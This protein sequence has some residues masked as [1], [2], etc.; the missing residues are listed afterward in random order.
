MGLGFR[1]Y[2]VFVGFMSKLVDFWSLLYTSLFIISRSNNKSLPIN[3][4]TTTTSFE[5]HTN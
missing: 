1:V 4:S 5:T 2:K 3:P